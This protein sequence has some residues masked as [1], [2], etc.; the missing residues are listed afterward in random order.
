MDLE[1]GHPFFQESLS[2]A[3]KNI[4]NYSVRGGA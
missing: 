2:G 3:V 1:G 4:L